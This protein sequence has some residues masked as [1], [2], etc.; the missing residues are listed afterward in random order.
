MSLLV[1]IFE[2]CRYTFWV[3][4]DSLNFLVQ[5][6]G[7]YEMF[8]LNSFAWVDGGPCTL[9]YPNHRFKITKDSC[10]MVQDRGL[11][12]IRPVFPL[13]APWVVVHVCPLCE[14]LSVKLVKM[15][16]HITQIECGECIFTRQ[17]SYMYMPVISEFSKCCIDGVQMQVWYCIWQVRRST[18][19]I[20][21]PG[22]FYI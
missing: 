5:H 8:C 4:V 21:G 11:P 18:H 10:S 22:R 9:E 20:E 13:L 2:P 7:L 14:G 15:D 12:W 16:T 3:F 6:V 19:T 17:W 1:A